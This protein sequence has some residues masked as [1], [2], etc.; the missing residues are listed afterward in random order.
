M[1]VQPMRS[2]RDEEQGKGGRKGGRNAE[3]DGG[4]EEEDSR[5]GTCC[6]CRRLETRF[7][8]IWLIALLFSFS[9]FIT[10]LVCNWFAAT[11]LSFLY[12]VS[13]IVYLF[14]VMLYSLGMVV[15]GLFC[16]F[17]LGC[18]QLPDCIRS[19]R[20]KLDF[21]VLDM[22]RFREYLCVLFFVTGVIM[23]V[24]VV[25]NS[26]GQN[27]DIVLLTVLQELGLSLPNDVQLHVFGTNMTATT[28]ATQ[29]AWMTVR[30][31]NHVL[32]AHQIAAYP[33]M[34]SAAAIQVF[35][36]S[37]CFLFSS[38]SVDVHAQ[39]W[40]QTG[41]AT[42]ITFGIWTMVTAIMLYSDDGLQYMFWN[43]HAHVVYIFAGVLITQ[44]IT[45]LILTNCC[46]K[47]QNPNEV[48]LWGLGSGTVGH[49]K[50]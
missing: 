15:H 38:F 33:V 19:T 30:V 32:S 46:W 13:L 31:N 44:F 2:E 22:N 21:G 4:E 17:T 8:W 9:L 20:K 16:V 40:L 39:I 12:T 37:A 24:E 26:S 10:S 25:G 11:I 18:C 36:A 34:Y 49:K 7:T 3:G 14:P 1:N 43:A 6:S 35:F 28:L 23:Y 50:D 45:V 48:L 42:I 5:V 27:S 47:T 29:G 41:F